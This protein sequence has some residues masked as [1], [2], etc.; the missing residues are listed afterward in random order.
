MPWFQQNRIFPLRLN[1][2]L[3]KVIVFYWT[4]CHQP[5]RECSFLGDEWPFKRIHLINEFRRKIFS[6]SFLLFRCRRF[7]FRLF[8]SVLCWLDWI[9][10]NGQKSVNY[11]NVLCMRKRCMRWIIN[12]KH[13][14][15]R[16]EI[17]TFDWN[18]KIVE[19]FVAVAHFWFRTDEKWMEANF[20]GRMSPSR[21]A[22]RSPITWQIAWEKNGDRK[23]RRTNMTTVSTPTESEQRRRQQ[24]WKLL[25]DEG[26]KNLRMNE[27]TIRST[28]WHMHK[29]VHTHTHTASVH[30]FI[31]CSMNFLAVEAFDW[32]VLIV[33]KIRFFPL[34]HFYSFLFL[35][36]MFFILFCARICVSSFQFRRWWGIHLRDLSHSTNA[37]K[38][39]R[40]ELLLTVFD[41][42]ILISLL[43]PSVG[44]YFDVIFSSFRCPFF[45]ESIM[46]TILKFL[47]IFFYF[48]T[49]EI[50]LVASQTDEVIT[51]NLFNIS[52]VLFLCRFSL[53]SALFFSFYYILLVLGV[54]ESR[55][56]RTLAQ[57]R[58]HR[59]R[60][61]RRNGIK[62]RHGIFHLIRNVWKFWS[63]SDSFAIHLITNYTW[64]ILQ[65]V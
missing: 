7:F 54:T 8:L 37:L 44:L 56:T 64:Y 23:Y 39:K 58:I 25:S 41:F 15:D 63:D 60:R 3:T 49:L 22:R 29:H 13:L 34:H 27:Q 47:L 55:K 57:I 19:I 11:E 33:P 16:A 35:F 45:A 32:Y 62:L 17:F 6:N 18:D 5:T 65:T 38:R 40:K 36:F 26:I 48:F 21:H 51:V 20:T 50:D 53:R 14:L 28:R 43:C 46:T 24:Q 59:R 42:S 61:I 52:L 10:R 2:H 12:M 4:G 1:I 9:R 31:Y 30:Y